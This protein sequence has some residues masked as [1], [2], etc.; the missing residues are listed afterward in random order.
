MINLERYMQEAI[1]EAMISL[2]EGNHGFGAVIVKDNKVISKAHDLEETNQDP[3]S[4]AEINAIRLAARMIGKNLNGCILLSTHEPCPMCSTAILWS[5]INHLAYGYSISESLKQ[6]GKRINLPCEELFARAEKEMKVDKNVLINQCSILYRQDVRSE[7]ER[8]RNVTFEKLND[9]NTNSIR[10]RLDWF[11]ENRL[12][13]TF[14]NHDL[15]DSAYNLLLC[16]L[17]I[18]RSKAQIVDRTDY[19]IVFHSKNFCPTLE[20]CKILNYDTRYICK[21]YNENATDVLIKQ[22]DQRLR[23]ERNY[24]KLRPYSDYCEEMI[25]LEKDE[26]NCL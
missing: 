20:A 16:R 26:I 2:R 22:I 21:H 8:L 6:G 19:R 18:D 5:G 12:T 15:V 10:R 11:K 1:S 24:D 3:T 25:I 13:F 7:I 17:N 14:I 23:F 9:Y 4:H